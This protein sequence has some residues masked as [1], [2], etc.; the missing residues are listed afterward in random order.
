MPII[1]GTRKTVNIDHKRKV[2]LSLKKKKV[3]ITISGYMPIIKGTHIT[4][5]RDHKRKVHQLCFQIK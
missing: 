5:N 1:K 2:Q 3:K 4:R